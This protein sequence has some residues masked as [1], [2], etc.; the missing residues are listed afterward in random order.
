M[1]FFSH[2]VTIDN[3]ACGISGIDHLI[4]NSGIEDFN[5][6]VIVSPDAGGVV[7]AKI[8]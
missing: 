1:G 2:Q 5:N 7:R 4:E 3:L 6:C 8:F